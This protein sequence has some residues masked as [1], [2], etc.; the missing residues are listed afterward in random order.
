MQKIKVMGLIIGGIA[1]ASSQTYGFNAMQAFSNCSRGCGSGFEANEQVCTDIYLYMIGVKSIPLWYNCGGS[2]SI[3]NVNGSKVSLSRKSYRANI[4]KACNDKGYWSISPGCL[5]TLGCSPHYTSFYCQFKLKD[6]YI[7]KL[8]A[9]YG[10]EYDAANISSDEYSVTFEGF[11]NESYKESGSQKLLNGDYAYINRGNNTP[12]IYSQGIKDMKGVNIELK[13]EKNN[14]FN[15]APN[16]NVYNGRKFD[17]KEDKFLI[18]N[19]KLDYL[20]YELETPEITFNRNGIL[21][22]SKDKII[23]YLNNSNFYEKL[24]LSEFEKQNSIDVIIKGLE[25]KTN[26]YYYLNLLSDRTIEDIV[27]NNINKDVKVIRK[28]IGIYPTNNNIP[29]SGKFDFP[30][31]NISGEHL[32][33]YGEIIVN[34]NMMVFWE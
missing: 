9:I 27:K 32:K 6:K 34:G 4:S 5:T 1:F 30:T 19:K 33:D 23:D 26:K 20:Y 21:F 14:Y 2:G 10:S 22:D 13:S 17:I 18:D 29:N 7:D 11:K 31:N 24:G 12:Y 8:T 3:W 15:L 28:Y 16:F 25:D